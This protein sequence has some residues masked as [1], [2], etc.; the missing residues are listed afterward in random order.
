MTTFGSKPRSTHAR[1][2]RCSSMG[3]GAAG[4]A[5]R[6]GRAT[7]RLTFPARTSAHAAIRALMPT[8]GRSKTRDSADVSV[9]CPRESSSRG[10]CLPR[11]R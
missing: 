1:V 3:S 4:E 10:A 2:S 7:G 8:L 5:A 9:S 11:V 6:R